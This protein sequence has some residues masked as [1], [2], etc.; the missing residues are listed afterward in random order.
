MLFA[1]RPWILYVGF[2]IMNC[3]QHAERQLWTKISKKIE[4]RNA[5]RLSFLII[6]L[7]KKQRYFQT[8]WIAI[9]YS[10]IFPAKSFID[11]KNTSE[12]VKK[13]HF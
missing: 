3:G 6:P 8:A 7:D 9:A 5:S 12:N 13:N 11:A 1:Y 2:L 10:L 4:F